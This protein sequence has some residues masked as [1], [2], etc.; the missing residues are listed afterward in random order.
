MIHW[1][2]HIRSSH[3]SPTKLSRLSIGFSLKISP[4]IY[5]YPPQESSNLPRHH[6]PS[7]AVFVHGNFIK[8]H[9][10]PLH[11]GG[12][13]RPMSGS[14]S[15]TSRSMN[16]W[17]KDQWLE[18]YIYRKTIPVTL[19]DMSFLS[20]FRSIPHSEIQ[21]HIGF[22]KFLWKMDWWSP[23]ETSN[24]CNWLFYYINYIYTITWFYVYIF[25]FFLYDCIHIYIYVYIYSVRF[26]IH[27][28][29][30][31]HVH[32]W[33]FKP[34]PVFLAQLSCSHSTIHQARGEVDLG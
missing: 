17:T 23:P 11:L 7:L 21:P 24:C 8:V 22:C 26:V 32:W 34:R 29:L 9:L 27:N 1:N 16:Q 30:N 33:S 15:V 25:M 2:Y 31:P 4:I 28:P 20:I 10:R 13:L 6:R 5:R 3:K 12:R 19:E 18:G 14:K